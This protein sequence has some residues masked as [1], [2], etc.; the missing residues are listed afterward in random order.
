M[1]DATTVILIYT[2]VALL[3]VAGI[4]F[5]AHHYK[6]KELEPATVPPS[7]I[8][9]ETVLDPSVWLMGTETVWEDHRQR[10]VCGCEPV[11]EDVPEEVRP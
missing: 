10:C 2:L 4:S 7:V 8:I 9:D 1:R 5:M 11:P 6:Y 3:V